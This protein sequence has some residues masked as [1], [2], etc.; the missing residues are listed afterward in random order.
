[1][2]NYPTI[3]NSEITKDDFL[4]FRD[5]IKENGGIYL[6]DSRFDSLRVSLLART[7]YLGFKNYR[8]YYQYLKFHPL[9]EEEFRKL[10]N[11][12]TVNETCFFRN[13]GHFNILKN[14]IL[15]EILSYGDRNNKKVLRI[16]SAG[17]STGEEP[18]SLAMLVLESLQSHLNHWQIEIL[19]T[20][21]SEKALETA[22]AG[23]YGKRSLRLVDTY[24][25]NK[26][27]VQN[28][29]FFEL[30]IRVK[31]MVVFH[32]FN[33]VKEPYPLMQMNNWDIIFCCNVM[34]YFKIA[35]IKRVVQNFYN[36]LQEGGYFFTGYAE[37]FQNISHQ[38]Q[39]INT[40]ECFFYK[41]PLEGELAGRQIDLKKDTSKVPD[42]D[43][44]QL[45]EEEKVGEVSQSLYNQA[46][47]LFIKEEYRAALEKIEQYVQENKT[48]VNGLLLLA[49]VSLETGNMAAALLHSK[50]V[51]EVN[52]FS[53]SAYYILGF[54]H[55]QS[56]NYERAIEYFT[57]AIFLH[58][59][60][61]LAYYHL[62]LIYIETGDYELAVR[63]F[64][65]AL[66]IL[67][68]LPG[69]KPLDL[70]GHFTPA[71]L[72]S[73]CEKNIEDLPKATRN[74]NKKGGD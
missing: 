31:R 20:D 59:D 70:S 71:L 56:K 14:S 19:G 10:I 17:C 2:T 50:N 67:K 7:T 68:Q 21:I 63:E 16:W 25:K 51:I 29:N 47:E 5:F 69:N 9:G 49:R 15:P 39:T 52:P 6:D 46:M 40:P 64:K 43:N 36:S 45:L 72:I 8:Q 62:G 42:E 3:K 55:K 38:F 27:F 4:L 58:K 1:M 60:F 24:Y 28:N 35:T 11:H 32:Y 61:A 26:Y 18:Y 73:V 37:S 57:K 23:I 66:R 41:K 33:L 12:I 74:G 44:V 48:D 34:I 53:E 13:A 30:D 22:V 65:N 54:V